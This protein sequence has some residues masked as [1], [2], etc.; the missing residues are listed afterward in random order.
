MKYI[1]MVVELTLLLPCLA[2]GGKFNWK[3]GIEQASEGLRMQRDR[4]MFEQNPEL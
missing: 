1:I 3:A 4:Q 2:F